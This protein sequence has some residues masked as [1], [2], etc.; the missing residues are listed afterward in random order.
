MVFFASPP[1]SQ[2]YSRLPAAIEAA[3][4]NVGYTVVHL[5]TDFD[6][7]IFASLSEYLEVGSLAIAVS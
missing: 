3:C 2:P 5:F 4:V 7:D 6:D 1:Y